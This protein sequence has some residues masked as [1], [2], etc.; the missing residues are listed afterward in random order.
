M[1]LKEIV[2]H[3][4]SNKMNKTVTVLVSSKVKH[5]K[6]SKIIIKT[7]KYYAHDENNQYKI[8]D[9]VKIQQTRPISKR[10]SW[11]VIEVIN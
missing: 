5:K 10:K 6:Y 3:I 11:K 4:T 9:K 8:G 1:T 2:G 7:K